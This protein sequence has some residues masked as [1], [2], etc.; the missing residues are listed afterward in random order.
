M[1]WWPSIQMG[2]NRSQWSAS[3]QVRAGAGEGTLERPGLGTEAQ[4]YWQ[5]EGVES[6]WH[7][8]RAG[9]G[10]SQGWNLGLLRSL[11]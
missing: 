7:G 4:S 11:G 9:P 1:T 3:L 10:L 8:L 5:G 6:M 2:M